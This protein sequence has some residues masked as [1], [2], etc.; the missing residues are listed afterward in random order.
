MNASR[1][2]VRHNGG[3]MRTRCILF[4]VFLKEKGDNMDRTSFFSQ[5]RFDSALAGAYGIEREFFLSDEEGMPVPRS[6]EFLA[7]MNDSA[8][9]YELSA[10]QVE[11]RTSPE[12]VLARIMASL[13]ASHE[14][15]IAVA[16]AMGAR[17]IALE[18]AP[19]NMSLDVYP[20]DERYQLLAKQLPCETLRAACRVA[21]IHIHHGA[22][23]LEDAIRIHNVV[24]DR[25]EDFIRMGDHSNG[26]RMR[27]YQNMA[28]NW[29]PPRYESAEHLYTVAREQGFAS[30]P[31]D[32]WHLVR[33]SRHGTVEL[34]MFGMTAELSRIAHW[35]GALGEVVANR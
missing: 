14:S 7:R 26:E 18:V 31:R 19:V 5:F 8:W 3:V 16:Q 12:H 13:Q 35:I 17:L 24:V 22:K 33:I 20:H 6:P 10:C 21:G 27:L 23:N 34:R 30:N 2:H 29:K 28:T 1:P 25:L 15:A 9:T 32:C 11:H 4:L